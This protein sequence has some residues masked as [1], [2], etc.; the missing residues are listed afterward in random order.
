MKRNTVVRTMH[1][2]GLAIWFG[3]SL[4]GA[5]G[6]NGAASAVDDRRERTRVASAGWRRWTPV[7]AAG[8]A[9]YVV[10]SAGLLLA[11]RGRVTYQ[12]GVAANTA[13]KTLLTGVALAATAYSR[14]LGAKI[15]QAGEVPA[16][17]ATKP[18][19]ATPEDIAK[20]Q[21]QLSLLQWAIPGVTGALVALTSLHGEQQR[22][23]EVLRGVVK[24]A[25]SSGGGRR[26]ATGRFARKA[27]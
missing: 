24:G 22:P 3:G 7:N 6:L 9:M 2:V 17:G 23:G 16:E 19:E 1:D 25:F 26:G 12:K 8:I 14:V 13:A 21:R 4:M 18:D 11:N 5:V 27:A 10:G 20:A 15:D